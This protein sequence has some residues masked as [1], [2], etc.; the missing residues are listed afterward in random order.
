MPVWAESSSRAGTPTADSMRCARAIALLSLTTLLLA[1]PAAHA[2]TPRPYVKNVTPLSVSVGETMTVQGFYFR[3]GYRENTVVF[4]ASDGRVSY[5]KS[6][7]STRKKLTVIVPPKVERLLNT[8]ANG[9]R[10][11]TKVRIKVIARRM[12]RLAKRPLAQ[13]TVGPDVGGDCDKDGTPNPSDGDDDN[14]QLPDSIE[15]TI[16]TNPCV[17]DSDGDQLLDGWEYLSALDLNRNALPYPGKKPYP[18]ALFDDAN[19]DYDGDGLHAWVEHG[20]WWLAGRD[21]PLNYSDGDQTTSPEAVGEKTWNDWDYDGILSDD[22]RDYDNDGLANIYEY[23]SHDFEP[24]SPPFPSTF[25]PDYLDPDSDGDGVLDGADDQDH[26]DVSN[27]DELRQGTWVM[28]PCDPVF[29]LDFFGQP[30]RDS[31]GLPIRLPRSRTCP[32]WMDPAEA[33][34]KPKYACFSRTLLVMDRESGP[35][36]PVNIGRDAVPW[37][38]ESDKTP[39]D[40]GPQYCPGYP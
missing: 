8:D 10:V 4:V 18:N 9:V 7:H 25:R 26:D 21:Y 34:T 15:T 40:D 1:V 36:V 24:W 27:I 14:D 5:V 23:R 31:L 6:E 19:V 37:L 30:I 13:P 33:P 29:R 39:S 16:R 17:A 22:E 3:K 35:P 11:P 12:S 20:F 28:N 38:D 32:R 2:R